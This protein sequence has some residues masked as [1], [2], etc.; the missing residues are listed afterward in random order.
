MDK[1]HKPTSITSIE[2]CARLKQAL[3][4]IR[5]SEELIILLAGVV[6][7]LASQEMKRV[8]SISED[9]AVIVFVKRGKP[10]KLNKFVR[11]IDRVK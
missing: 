6:G 7:N 4:L 9:E 8:L 2:T 11:A 1:P 5:N 3:D 10:H